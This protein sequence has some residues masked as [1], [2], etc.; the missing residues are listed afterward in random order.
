MTRKIVLSPPAS[1]RPY[2]H[3][4]V[5]SDILA[6]HFSPEVAPAVPLQHLRVTGEILLDGSGPRF[7]VSD[8]KGNGL[9]LGHDREIR[10]W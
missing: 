3:H 2:Q 10:R 7:R 9:E 6:E 8:V 4:R 5:D 1:E